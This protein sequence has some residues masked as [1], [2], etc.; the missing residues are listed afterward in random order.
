[1]RSGRE[2]AAPL[3]P[4][5]FAR[6]M[7]PRLK[8]LVP[9]PGGGRPRRLIRM[10]CSVLERKLCHLQETLHY[11][12]VRVFA[13]APGLPDEGPLIKQYNVV[14]NKFCAEL[15]VGELEEH[16]LLQKLCVHPEWRHQGIASILL[17]WGQDRAQGGC[18]GVPEFDAGGNGHVWEGGVCAGC[19]LRDGAAGRHSA[20]YGVAAVI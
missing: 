18:R 14:Y 15:W 1:M 13:L 7:I 19:E 20:I 2:K 6:G 3:Q 10:L 9:W 5:Q 12:F 4:W 16:W 11:P 8:V 17:R